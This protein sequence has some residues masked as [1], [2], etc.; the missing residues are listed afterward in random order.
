MENDLKKNNL[1][2]ISLIVGLVTVFVGFFWVLIAESSLIGLILLG[3]GAVS[4]GILIFLK[5]EVVLKFFKEFEWGNFALRTSYIVIIIAVLILINI[6]ANKRFY[7]ADLTSE[8]RYTLSDHTIKLLKQID[9]SDRSVKIL[10]FR[11]DAPM[12]EVVDDLLKEYKARSSKITI[13]YVDPDR[14]PILAKKYNIRSIGL[15][16]GGGRVY[17]TVI[18]LSGGLKESVDVVKIKWRQGRGRQAQPTLALSENIEKDISSALLRISKN[19]KKVYFVEGHGEVKI[20]DDSKNGWAKTKKVISDENYIIDKIYLAS[21]GTIPKD[22]S[23]LIMASP[24]RNLL[25][26]EIDLLNKYLETGGHLLLL[27]EP[28][29]VI[30]IN[31]FL[32]KWGVKFENKLVV[33]PKANY[34]FQP[35]IPLITEY[36]YHPITKSLKYAT[37][38]PTLGEVNKLDKNDEGAAVME[39]A[40]T[41]PESWAE[42]DISGN[43]MKYNAGIDKKGPISV[44]V[45]V[46][47]NIDKNK[48]KEMRMVVIGDS[49]FAGNSSV[50]S[51]GN[52]DLLLNSINWLAGKEELIGIRSKAPENRIIRIT[53]TRLRFI[54]YSCV[55]ILP[56]LV[57]ILGVI[58]WLKRR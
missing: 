9:K 15:P 11:T 54:F 10:F 55:V 25:P 41:S 44:M 8:K 4:L 16:Y 31:R 21:A 23:V 35:L 47:K 26:Q 24:E 57:I 46:S 6:V 39:I 53:G 56:L 28:L 49:D 5:W 34:W 30:N 20:D 33:D 27:L 52:A 7:R 2:I 13:K 1:I 18:L 37:F 38:F 45:A 48:N 29:N 32:N 22:C 58:I 36:N 43:K 17:G 3:V 12:L 40:K 42:S 19:K 14:D 50:S 51:Y